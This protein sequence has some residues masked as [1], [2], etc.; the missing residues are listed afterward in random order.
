[1]SQTHKRTQRSSRPTGGSVRLATGIIA[2]GIA[3]RLQAGHGPGSFGSRNGQSPRGQQ[4][5]F[6]Q[7]SSGRRRGPRDVSHQDSQY[8]QRAG[9][10]KMAFAEPGTSVVIEHWGIPVTERSILSL[11]KGD[12]SKIFN[13][14][15][16]LS[17]ESTGAAFALL[18]FLTM[19]MPSPDD[20]YTQQ[21]A[22]SERTTLLHKVW[23]NNQSLTSA[24]AG[25]AETSTSANAKGRATGRLRYW[26]EQYLRCVYGMRTNH[27][28]EQIRDGL[29]QTAMDLEQANSTDRQAFA[30]FMLADITLVY[31]R[32]IVGSNTLMVAALILV[33]DSYPDA[34]QL[35]FSESSRRATSSAT[36]SASSPA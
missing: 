27:T 2:E 22:R 3:R 26:E 21:R 24:E 35:E 36:S 30:L 8:R 15:P 14:L 5:D 32:D 25:L 9:R 7:R 13:C 4:P 1:M 29:K 17:L 12:V 28:V 11:G 18:N 6:D 20:G 16:Q 19:H 34:I 23:P 31:Y 33:Q 10:G